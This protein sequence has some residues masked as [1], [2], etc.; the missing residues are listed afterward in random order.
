[1]ARLFYGWVVVAGAF[2]VLFVAYGAQYS[3]GVFFAALLDE[4]GWSRASLAGAFSLYAF[5]YSIMGFPAGRL[6]DVW[7]PRR[8]IVV[9]GCFL[10]V[11]LAGMAA[12]SQLW[13]PYV[14]YG[15][16]AAMG[17]STAYVPCHATVLR[18]F[19]ERRGL[20]IGIASSGASVGT[21]VLPPLAQ[22]LVGVTGWRTAYIVFG[23]GV[24]VVLSLV[25]LV[26]R[27][28][29][30]SAGLHPDGGRPRAHQPSEGEAWSLKGAARTPVFWL[31]TAAFSA[32]W[33]PVFIPLVH[34][35]RLSQDLGFAPLVG[36]S[37]ISALGLGAVTGR[38]TMG[39]LSDRIG[40]RASVAVGMG[41]QAAAFMGFFGVQSAA[42]LFATAF[43]FGYSYGAVSALFTA[44]VG[45]FFGRTHA[46]TLVGVLFAMAGSMA[47]W[48]PFIAGAIHDATGS[49]AVAFLL[50]AALNI[51]AIAILLLCQPPRLAH[52]LRLRESVTLSPR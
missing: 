25:A 13:Q 26:M 52:P 49:Y 20:A 46:G 10:G 1:M 14:L 33:L 4:F 51:L 27:R 11:A 3:F 7:G 32:T 39:V 21:I 8:V 34:L 17:M 19:V 43:V 50:A 40:R 24:L 22:G 5:A 44:M 6:T 31:L 37:V 29:P 9:G 15:L 30:E 45:D 18:W 16:V 36:A 35:V 28:D 41:L 42:M 2:V 48:G 23:L 38:L 47:G 12:V